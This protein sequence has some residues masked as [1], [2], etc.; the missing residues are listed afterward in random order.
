MVSATTVKG[1][2]GGHDIMLYALSTCVWCNKTKKLLDTLGFE[3]RYIWVDKL[4][5]QNEDEVMD[6]VRKYNPECTFPT[7]VIDGK[8]CI[9]GFKEP[10][11][12]KAL[13]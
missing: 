10:E 1:K 13:S 3:Y 7:M 11:I 6:E 8:K 2:Q 12:R 5:G 9:V 4:S